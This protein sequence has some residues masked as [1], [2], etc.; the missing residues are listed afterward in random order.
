MILRGFEN[1]CMNRSRLIR[2]LSPLQ[3]SRLCII[4]VPR[5]IHRV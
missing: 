5:R 4:R 1:N 3:I 2:R